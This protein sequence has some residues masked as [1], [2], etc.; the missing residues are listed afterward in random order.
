MPRY[1]IVCVTTADP[2]RHVTAVGIGGSAT[3][4]GRRMSLAAVLTAMNAGDKFFTRSPSTEQ[5]AEVSKAR[6]NECRKETLRSSADAVP[7]NNLDYL[8]LC[9]G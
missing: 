9:S 6:C 4:P 2:H 8:T 3:K 7:D 5:E 1:Q